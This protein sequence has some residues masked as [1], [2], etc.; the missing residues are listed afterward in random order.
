MVIFV[1]NSESCSQQRRSQQ[2]VRQPRLKGNGIKI[3]PLKP[4][5]TGAIAPAYWICQM[6]AIVWR[7]EN[8]SLNFECHLERTQLNFFRCFLLAPPIGWFFLRS[9]RKGNSHVDSHP[10]SHHVGSVSLPK[11][12]VLF[13]DVKFLVKATKNV[14]QL[15]ISCSN[16]D[17]TNS[18]VSFDWHA[19]KI[20]LILYNQIDSIHFKIYLLSKLKHL[21]S[22]LKELHDSVCSP[23]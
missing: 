11:Q 16:E 7:R 20:L 9:Q 1:F 3:I 8:L 6:E 23:C 14:T 13:S 15:K 18:I 21:L 5:A 22:R 2:S 19:L 17:P 4:A 12:C 10:I